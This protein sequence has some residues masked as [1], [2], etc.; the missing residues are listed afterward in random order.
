MGAECVIAW[1]TRVSVGIAKQGASS[2]DQESEWT[3]QTVGAATCLLMK[4]E[5]VAQGVSEEDNTEAFSTKIDSM[6]VP[7]APTMVV[8]GD[9]SRSQ[10]KYMSMSRMQHYNKY[11][12]EEIRVGDYL[13]QIARAHCGESASSMI[14]VAS[15]AAKNGPTAA[16]KSTDISITLMPAYQNNHYSEDELRVQDHGAGRTKLVNDEGNPVSL[17]QDTIPGYKGSDKYYCGQR[18]EIPGSDGLCGPTAGPQCASCLRFQTKAPSVANSGCESP[19]V[20]RV[21][22]PADLK[23]RRDPTVS[24]NNQVGTLRA[25]AVF[26]FKEVRDGWAKLSPLHYIDLQSSNHTCDISDF[27]EHN[28]DIQG[29]SKIDWEGK[30]TLEEPSDEQKSAVLALN[31]KLVSTPS[32]RGV[33]KKVMAMQGVVRQMQNAVSEL[34]SKFFQVCHS[35]A[36]ARAHTT[37]ARAHTWSDR[38]RMPCQLRTAS[39][40]RSIQ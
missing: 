39:A 22:G 8:D 32:L 14:N 16:D 5:P 20:L 13:K 28:P 27:K 24:S 35:T 4:K 18:R 31:T 6:Q 11:S 10:A 7:F 2:G 23:V 34:H 33:A 17:G 26:A 29:Y 15:S 9:S 19:V 38:C 1:E 40:S 12:F 30:K 36:H 3:V 21:V 25:G 37:H